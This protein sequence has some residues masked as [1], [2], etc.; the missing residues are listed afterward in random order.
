MFGVVFVSDI[1]HAFTRKCRCYIAFD[2][3]CLLF[4]GFVPLFFP[5]IKMKELEYF[6][7]KINKQ[8]YTHV[9]SVTSLA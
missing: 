2:V 5:V 7:L 8:T 3:C 1:G 9:Q 6:L 4:G